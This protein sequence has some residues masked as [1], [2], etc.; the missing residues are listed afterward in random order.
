MFSNEFF[1]VLNAIN[2]FNKLNSGHVWYRGTS[3]STYR[4][5]SSLFRLKYPSLN[6]YLA[7]ERQQLQYIDIN[8][9]LLDIKKSEL[10]NLEK[11]YLMQHHGLRTRLLD[12]TS[13]LGVA[14]YFLSLD[15][16]SDESSRLWMLNPEKF[17]N[18]SVGK[19]GI[20][21]PQDY[22]F[23]DIHN[24]Q[25]SIAIFPIRNNN[26]IIAQH[27]YF[28]VQGNSLK[29]L[30][31]EFKSELVTN[32]ALSY[33]DF[34]YALKQNVIDYLSMHDIHSFSIFPDMLGLKDYIDTRLIPL[35]AK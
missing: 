15:W 26:R 11:L 28:T 6:D 35:S 30:E 12:W 5:D 24:L 9:T 10:T 25:H 3:K 20:I 14:L 21:S 29:P 7:L 22:L 13:N 16:T 8:S 27:G 2:N 32:N 19:H 33:I 31:N 17:N 23:S 34:D 4:L 18:I 1:E